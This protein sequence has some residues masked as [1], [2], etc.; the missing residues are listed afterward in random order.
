M[1]PPAEAVELRRPSTMHVH[2]TAVLLWLVTLLVAGAG[3]AA[4]TGAPPAVQAENTTVDYSGE[5]VTIVTER[6]AT[7]TGETS[8]DAGTNL[9]LI[10]RSSG[11]N[12][13]LTMNRTTV[14]KDGRFAATFDLADVPDGANATLM[15]RSGG[16]QQAEV[17]VHLVAERTPTPTDSPTPD[18][19]PVPT[20][21]PT[22][23]NMSSGDGPGFGGLVALFAVLGTALA[24]ARRA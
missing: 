5:A 12:P 22:P 8:L 20:D 11:E 3:V 15:V 14:R 24:V 9:T 1:K 6:D 4:A 21:S 16:E 17:P 23:S 19:T 13:F 7:V 2:R 10:M 18:P